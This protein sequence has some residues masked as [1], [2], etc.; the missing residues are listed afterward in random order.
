MASLSMIMKEKGITSDDLATLAQDTVWL[1]NKYDE[2][3]EQ[4]PNE[5]VAA[6][7]KRVI[8]HDRDMLALLERLKSKYNDNISRF[9]IEFV[10]AEDFELILPT[11]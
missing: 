10:S 7:K 5:Y 11:G 8:D 9:A 2:L 6:Y 1:V 3:R 4:Y